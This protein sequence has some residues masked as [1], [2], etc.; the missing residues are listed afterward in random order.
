MRIDASENSAYITGG[1]HGIGWEIAKKLALSGCRVAVSSSN[2][3]RVEEAQHALDGISEDNLCLVGDVLNDADLNSVASQI[4]EEWGGIDILVNNVGG[5]GRWGNECILK[6]D[7]EVWSQVYNKNLNS[8]LF[9]T[10]FF[11]PY[12]MKNKWGRVITITSIFGTQ[13][14]SR[15]WF[16]IA[17]AAQTVLMKNLSCNK[18]Y[19]SSN[20][21]FN[22]VA[23]GPIY[24][25]GTGWHKIKEEDPER[26]ESYVRNNIPR[27]KM[28]TA[29]EVANVV[30]FLCSEY[31]ALVNGA[32]ISCDGGQG[33]CL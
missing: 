27:G 7:A 28:G 6:T 1:T 10:K 32:S 33:V 19:S 22:S 26:F 18:E 9:Y 29:Q 11:L 15:P 8:A 16:N 21:T 25:E 5:G 17:K 20:I 24:I 13:I 31:S 4:V 12:M 14:G 3:R 2:K 30:L 23:P